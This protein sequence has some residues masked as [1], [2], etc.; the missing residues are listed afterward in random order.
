MR[1]AGPL[2]SPSATA[3]CVRCAARC[4]P[5][6]QPM[7]VATL[8]AAR[9]HPW[10]RPHQ[11]A[12]TSCGRA[13]RPQ[14]W[15]RRPWRAA[16]R[17]PPAWPPGRPPPPPHAGAACRRPPHPRRC[18]RP[19]CRPHRR[20]HP[21]L[22]RGTAWS[23]AREAS[24]QRKDTTVL[25][26][27]CC[28]RGGWMR[29]YAAAEVGRQAW[30]TPCGAVCGRTG[31]G[32]ASRAGA[33]QAGEDLVGR[34]VHAVDAR[35]VDLDAR[36]QRHARALEVGVALLRRRLDQVAHLR[37]AVKRWPGRMRDGA[38]Q[39]AQPDPV[40]EVYPSE[41]PSSPG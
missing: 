36:V 34:G 3:G 32:A 23:R 12:R 6:C 39:G 1:C 10:R 29:C 24:S 8:A 37:A 2:A 27:A 4:L 11:T 13:G 40:T 7:H 14:R 5:R 41:R 21:R 38:P 30:T 35:G 26:C 33:R 15:G 17:H 19:R 16:R 9:P 25:P 22:Q 20:P 31:G 18:P 28:P